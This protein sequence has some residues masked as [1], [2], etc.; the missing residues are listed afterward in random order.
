MCPV[1]RLKMRTRN[2]TSEGPR[3]EVWGNLPNDLYTATLRPLIDIDLRNRRRLR[4]EL[5]R[6]RNLN[7]FL[8]WHSPSITLAGVTDGEIEML[9]DSFPTHLS[10]IFSIYND[11]GDIAL[12]VNLEQPSQ[13]VNQWLASIEENQAEYEFDRLQ[14]QAR[15][16]LRTKPNLY[17]KLA[18]KSFLRDKYRRIRQQLAHRFEQ[19]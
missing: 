8:L 9:I 1:Y 15:S 19:G 11:S 13:G 2:Q 3:P 17:R 14:Q 4:R 6:G 12:Y 7:Q 16:W 18:R 10:S 5:A